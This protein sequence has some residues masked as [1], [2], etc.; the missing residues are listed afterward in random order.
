MKKLMM[1]QLMADNDVQE[2]DTNVD[3]ERNWFLITQVPGSH[4]QWPGPRRISCKSLRTNE[5][6][7]KTIVEPIA[8]SFNT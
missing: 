5:R 4:S 3:I 8:T 2:E 1:V 6:S 7:G